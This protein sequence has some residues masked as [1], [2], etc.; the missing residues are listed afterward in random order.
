MFKITYN[1]YQRLHT[2]K[3]E[4]GE[5]GGRPTVDINWCDSV[6]PCTGWQIW[7]RRDRKHCGG[8]KLCNMIVYFFFNTSW[9]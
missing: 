2:T 3:K 9:N 6:R 4:I 7:H 1:Y 5:T 8:D